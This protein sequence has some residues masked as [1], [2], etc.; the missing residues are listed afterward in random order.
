MCFFVNA[1]LT[2]GE[3]VTRTF[4]PRHSACPGYGALPRH[5]LTLAHQCRPAAAPLG[6][7]ADI[8]EDEYFRG[9]VHALFSF[10]RAHGTTLFFSPCP[11]R[12]LL[13]LPSTQC[14]GGTQWPVPQA[15]LLDSIQI[16]HFP[17][18]FFLFC[19]SE[20]CSVWALKYF[21]ALI[22]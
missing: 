14:S 9:L 22:L 12:S 16:L 1:S 10:Q 15:P 3:T 6:P 5:V 2:Q 21:L 7:K 11:I 17:Q 8:W 13:Y 18:G 20:Y 19:I 4:V